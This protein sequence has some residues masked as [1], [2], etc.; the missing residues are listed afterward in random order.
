MRVTIL[1]CGGS[2]GVPAVSTGWGACDPTNP[3][4]R[5][6]RASILLQW[7]DSGL[8]ERSLLVDASP[9][10]REQSL[11][12]GLRRLDAL[13]VTHAHADHIHGL[14]DLREINRLMGGPLDLWARKEDL[15]VLE[16]RFGYCFTPLVPEATSIY[17]PI[18][19]KRM[20]EAGQSVRPVD[21]DGLE[22]FPFTQDHGWGTTLG[23]RFGAFA[24]STDVVR[25][26]EAAF[27]VLKGVDTWVVDCFSSGKHPTHAHVDLVLEWIDRVKPRQTILTHMGPG[28]DY[29]AL[30]TR[31]P[32]HTRP[33]YD[34]MVLLPDSGN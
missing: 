17:K 33:A 31:L 30:R 24:Y 9:D 5:R 11:S 12:V 4:N 14:D 1:G 15:E 7:R 26:N 10:F 19:T 21:G 6:R 8:L 34:G 27:E 20:L 16:D 23:L 28:L 2:G 3:L 22:M 32:S 29:E 18:L 13:V 25:L